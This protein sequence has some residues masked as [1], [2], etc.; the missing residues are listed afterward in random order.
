MKSTKRIFLLLA[1]LAPVAF[2]QQKNPVSSVV[3]DA[4]ARQEKNMVA[5][6]DEMPADKFD[7]RPTP[8]Q[9]TFAHLVLHIAEANYFLCSKAGDVP[10]A[11]KSELKD[12]DGKDK[13]VAGLKASF[14]YCDGA[15]AKADDSKLGDMVDAFGGKQQTGDSPVSPQSICTSSPTPAGKVGCCG[16]LHEST[17][18]TWCTHETVQCGAH[19]FSVTNSRRISA[20]V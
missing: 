19:D 6:A 4:L 3:K 12:T 20:T 8:P 10:A 7:F 15:L 2:A 13:L 1:F 5:A 11:P 18:D 16:A 9:E 14:D 17:I